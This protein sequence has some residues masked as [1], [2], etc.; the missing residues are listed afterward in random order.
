MALKYKYNKTDLTVEVCGVDEGDT[1]A[2]IPDTV[3]YYKKNTLSLK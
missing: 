3:E 1:V 2:N